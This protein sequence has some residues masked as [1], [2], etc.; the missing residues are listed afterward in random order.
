MIIVYWLVTAFVLGSVVGSFLNV[1]IARMPLEKSILWP[2]SRCT[3]CFQ[4]IKWYDNLPLV[5]Y[6]WLRGHC[7]Q[8]GSRFSVRYFIVE[9]LTG[10]GF[11]GLFYAEVVGNVHN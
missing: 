3:Q 6:L 1:C 4:G 5:S 9:R 10:L 7:R 11:A 8:C 2:G